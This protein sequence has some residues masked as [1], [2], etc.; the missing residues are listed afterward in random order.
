[1]KMLQGFCYIFKLFCLFFLILFAT[2]QSIIFFI[3]PETGTK[4]FD[5]F[6]HLLGEKIRLKSWDKYRGGLD[7]KGNI[8]FFHY[9]FLFL[10]FFYTLSI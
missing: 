7:V 8:I 5:K 4:D 1:M 10:L 9:Y 6:V 2:S 3:F